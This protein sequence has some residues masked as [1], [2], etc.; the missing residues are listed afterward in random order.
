[1]Q[2]VTPPAAVAY[3]ADQVH[4]PP[5]VAAVGAVSTVIGSAWWQLARDRKQQMR[6]S[7][8]GYL[9]SVKRALKPSAIVER[10]ARLL[11]KA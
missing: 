3:V 9:L 1:M 6:D 8:V 2:T 4:A 5:A 11:A 7:P 10:K